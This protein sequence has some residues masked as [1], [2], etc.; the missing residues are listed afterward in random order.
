MKRHIKDFESDLTFEVA[1]G[2]S[3]PKLSKTPPWT[4]TSAIAGAS[5]E[6][7]NET[8]ANEATTA[9]ERSP[10]TLNPKFPEHL[11]NSPYLTR[12]PWQICVECNRRTPTR[13]SRITRCET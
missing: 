3:N 1:S 4:S 6:Q 2:L 10:S 7:N 12:R 9:V 8:A 13:S 5:T 11:K